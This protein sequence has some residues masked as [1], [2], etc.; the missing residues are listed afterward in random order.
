ME[1]SACFFLL[2]I[3]SLSKFFKNY[4]ITEFCFNDRILYFFFI[5]P[6][7]YDTI[8]VVNLHS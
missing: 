7:I 2:L 8:P 6:Y 4:S 5:N 3:H 1:L